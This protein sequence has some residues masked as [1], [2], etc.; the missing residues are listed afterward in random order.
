MLKKYTMEIIKF[1]LIIV[2]FSC[3]GRA[4]GASLAI[5]QNKK[6]IQEYLN[7]ASY[8]KVYRACMV[9]YDEDGDSKTDCVEFVDAASQSRSI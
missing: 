9:T 8:Q 3:I 2:I 7:S 4:I 5:H 6:E 1:I